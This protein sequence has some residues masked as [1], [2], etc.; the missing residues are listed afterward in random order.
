GAAIGF[1]RVLAWYQERAERSNPQ[2]QLAIVSVFAVV[3]FVVGAALPRGAD[4]WQPRGMSAAAAEFAQQI[5]EG[6]RVIAMIEPT[7]AY[8]LHRN[9][10]PGFERTS[11]FGVLDTLSTP[12]YVITGTYVR[13][14][15]RLQKQLTNLSD[16]LTPVAGA[17]VVPYDVR[18]LDDLT[19]A[20]ARRYRAHPDS[21]FDL[22]L[23]RYL[24]RASR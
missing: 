4:P 3:V 14:S 6:S 24:P 22:R 11:Q 8:Y 18:L 13:R 16:R 17:K 5:P 23:F 9:G 20:E 7:I 2:L 1:Q 15:R 12:A 21:T 19:P 10:R